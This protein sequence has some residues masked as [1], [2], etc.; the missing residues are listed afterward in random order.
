[1]GVGTSTKKGVRNSASEELTQVNGESTPQWN[2]RIFIMH[3]QNGSHSRK[4][5]ITVMVLA[6][7]MLLASIGAATAG[8]AMRVNDAIWAHDRL[9]D[10]V[11][12]DTAFK[13]PPPQSTDVLFSFM[14]SGLDGA[15]LGGRNCPR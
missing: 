12:T 3:P 11:L 15:A 9:F 7:A 5:G 10:T 8:R 14:A 1:M 4:F 13:D 6:G 2:E